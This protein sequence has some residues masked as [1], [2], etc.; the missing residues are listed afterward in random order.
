MN[1]EKT[2][3]LDYCI[4]TAVAMGFVAFGLF[5]RAHVMFTWLKK[6]YGGKWIWLKKHLRLSST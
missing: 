6:Y 1:K 3:I 4:I 2:T 5:I